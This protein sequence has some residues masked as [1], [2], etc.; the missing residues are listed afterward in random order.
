M[1][2]DL[3]RAESFLSRLPIRDKLSQRLIPFKLNPSQIKVHL[4]LKAQQERRRT[5]RSV[6]LKARRQGISTYFDCL[7]GVHGMSRS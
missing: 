4:A 7:L 2:F 1:S 5:M 3:D 6:V